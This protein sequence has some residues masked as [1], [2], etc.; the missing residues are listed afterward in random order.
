MPASP[1]FDTAVVFPGMGPAPF[2]EVARFM[3]VNRQARRLL[4]EADEVLGY[5]VVDRYQEHGGVYSEYAQIAFLVN[6]LALLEWAEETLGVRPQVCAGPS[7]GSKAAAVRSG[8]LA[9]ADAVRMTAALSHCEDAW[10]ADHF[11]DVVTQSFVRVPEERLAEL[12]AELDEQ[13]EWHELS[14][15]VD[16]DFWMLSLRE[17]CLD[18]FRERVRAV[19]GMPLYTMRPPMHCRSF[20]GLRDL[21][22]AEVIGR[23]EFRDPALPIVADQDGA[24]LTTG[25]QVRTL[26]LDG[27]VRT[28]RWPGVVATLK[29]LGVGR[30]C[31]A[32]PDGM[33]GRVPCTTRNFEVTA[34]DPRT[35]M[36]PRRRGSVPVA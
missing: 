31:V 10:F 2:A 19:G 27:Y 5:S 12:L 24:V 30:V 25:E 11:S 9:F 1:S 7:F 15:H 29:R 20:G 26:L 16:D 6:C 4:A 14:C 32:G 17:R 13:R 33:F 18:G 23:L 35:A 8:A 36:L 3:L 21:V 28:V 34:V 22:E